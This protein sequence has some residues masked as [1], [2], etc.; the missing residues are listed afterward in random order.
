MNTQTLNL[1][2]LQILTMLVVGIAGGHIA[3]NW[4]RQ[5][6][7]FGEISAGILLGPAV[8]GMLAP[9]I[10]SMLFPQRGGD[11]SGLWCGHRP[12]HAVFPVCCRLGNS[13]LSTARNFS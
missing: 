10:Y 2:L 1:L 3:R 7:V 5:P 13:S 9:G 11:R 8:L 12:E 4:L 6:S